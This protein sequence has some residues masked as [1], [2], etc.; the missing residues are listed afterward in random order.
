[1][2]LN[3]FGGMVGRF[4]GQVSLDSDNNVAGVGVKYGAGLGPGLNVNVPMFGLET[5]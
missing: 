4:G 5:Q 1:M 3:E 2:G